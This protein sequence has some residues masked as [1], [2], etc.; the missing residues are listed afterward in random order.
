MK[1][2]KTVK[3]DEVLSNSCLLSDIRRE[4]NNCVLQRTF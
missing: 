3:I 2:D 4:R 1:G